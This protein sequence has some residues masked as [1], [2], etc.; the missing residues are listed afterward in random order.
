MRTVDRQIS[1]VLCQRLGE[2]MTPVFASGQKE[3]VKRL[4]WISYRFDCEQTGAGNGAGRE[5]GV[6][7]GIEQ[8]LHLCVLF[9]RLWLPPPVAGRAFGILYGRIGLQEV[10]DPKP[11]VVDR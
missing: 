11:V 4:A 8:T 1:L 2:D 6:E 5:P 3:T 7:V 9:D 10:A